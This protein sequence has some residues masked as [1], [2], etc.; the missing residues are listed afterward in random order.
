MGIWPL[1]VLVQKM[2]FMTLEKRRHLLRLV[3][4]SSRDEFHANLQTV[5]GTKIENGPISA[6][7]CRF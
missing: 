2:N 3:Q 4:A 6:Y 7:V 5:L 1:V